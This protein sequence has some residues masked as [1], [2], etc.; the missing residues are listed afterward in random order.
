[1]D[2]LRSVPHLMGPVIVTVILAHWYRHCGIFL[3]ELTLAPCSSL[4]RSESL[5]LTSFPAGHDADIR[6]GRHC[7]IPIPVSD[8]M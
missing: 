2:L 8:A 3:I 5:G 6:G 1:M 4:S 7:V